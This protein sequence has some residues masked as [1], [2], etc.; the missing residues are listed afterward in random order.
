MNLN[1]DEMLPTHQTRRWLPIH[2]NFGLYIKSCR[3]LWQ[4]PRR[5]AT[6]TKLSL[7][8]VLSASISENLATEASFHLAI[9]LLQFR[10]SPWLPQM[11]LLGVVSPLILFSVLLV[12][13]ML[14]SVIVTFLF[15][16]LSYPRDTLKSEL[17][18]P[19]HSP[20]GLS[21]SRYCPSTTT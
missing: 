10:R 15:S 8:G 21:W 18:F 14:T 16:F 9:V 19:F 4:S 3:D 2:L 17:F 12:E 20:F 13:K 7:Q 1:S 6:P 11:L 5:T